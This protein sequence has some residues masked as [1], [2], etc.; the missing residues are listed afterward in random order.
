MLSLIL[1]LVL[2]LVG[3]NFLA[4]EFESVSHTR[5]NA[6]PEHLTR[7]LELGKSGRAVMAIVPVA[8]VLIF[9]FLL[10]KVW[11]A[12]TIVSLVLL[13]IMFGLYLFLRVKGFRTFL[14]WFFILWGNNL[15][16]IKEVPAA[17]DMPK[18]YVI[19]SIITTV[20]VVVMFILNII[21]AIIDKKDAAEEDEEDDNRRDA[22][23]LHQ[24]LIAVVCVA[25]VVGIGFGTYA[26]VLHFIPVS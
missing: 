7:S 15:V 26:L 25:V 18:W 21:F 12:S 9:Y 11:V 10:S 2:A 17:D 3:V 5:A 13:V 24:I 1:S 6:D 23:P 14:A 4:S 8:I 16:C 22:L 19:W 20:I